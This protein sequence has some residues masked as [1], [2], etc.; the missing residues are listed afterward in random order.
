V[1]LPQSAIVTV[2][3]KPTAQ[4]VVN[5]KVETRAIETG[6]SGNGMVEVRSGVTE[7]ETV[8]VRAGTFVRDGDQ[9][10]PIEAVVGAKG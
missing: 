10:T 3:G 6:I 7:G 2:A 9:V 8:I 5:G 1:T 4:V